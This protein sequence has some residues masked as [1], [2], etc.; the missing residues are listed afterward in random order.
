[1][2]ATPPSDPAA[3][4]WAHN[5]VT[6]ELAHVLSRPEGGAGRT[7]VELWLQPGAAVAGAH[8]HPTLVERFEVLEGRVTFLVGD[9]ERPL[10]PGD[11]VAEAPPETI[12][13][14]WNSGDGIARVRV[15]IEPAAGTDATA[16]DRFVEMIE[17]MWSLGARGDVND[18]GMPDPLWL[19]AIAREY[20]DVIVFV[21]PPAPVQKILFGLLAAIAGR[22][23][24]DPSDRSLHGPAAPLWIEDPGERLDE[25]LTPE[26]G[27]GA[28]RGHGAR[29]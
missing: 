17:T 1:M 28:A 14:W 24:R 26:V 9:R 5:P 13:D 2:A 23:G 22:F 15:E 12:H 19:A 27:A 6:G 3:P 16:A 29:P 20:R 7:E 25:L 10:G 11:G 21:R 8:I 18:K 4:H